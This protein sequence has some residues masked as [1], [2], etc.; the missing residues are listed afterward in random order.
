MKLANLPFSG[1]APLRE[2]QNTVSPKVLRIFVVSLLSTILPHLWY[3]ACFDNLFSV[4]EAST[5]QHKQ[6]EPYKQ[7]ISPVPLS[8]QTF[9]PA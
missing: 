6:H 3:C 2:I 7:N 9:K 1:F 5:K 8:S 4:I